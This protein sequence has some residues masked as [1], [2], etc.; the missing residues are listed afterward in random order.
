MCA[1][2]TRALTFNYCAAKSNEKDEHK[3]PEKFGWIPEEKQVGRPKPG[4]PAWDLQ[5]ITETPSPG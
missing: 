2:H 4:R 5:K 1:N 3:I